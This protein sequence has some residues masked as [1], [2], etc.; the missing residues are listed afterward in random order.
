MG[1]QFKIEETLAKDTTEVG[2]EQT[3]MSCYFLDQQEY[4]PITNSM[5][6]L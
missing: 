6:Y 5:V 4:D 2:F 1:W 3:E